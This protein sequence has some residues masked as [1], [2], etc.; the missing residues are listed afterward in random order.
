[1]TTFTTKPAD[2]NRKWYVIDAEGLRLGR[3]AALVS[4]YLR[5]KHKPIYAPNI[6]CGDNIIIINAEKVALTGNNKEN[7]HIIYW[8]TGYPGGLKQ[9]TAKQILEGKTPDKLIRKAVE[10]MLDRGPMGSKQLSKLHVYA[11]TAHPHDA[12]KPE[13]LDVA[14]LNPKNTSIKRS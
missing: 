12:Q 6:D 11:G 1:M 8:H 14:S 4:K 9:R 2:V 7:A 5:G 3:L 10:R 13:S